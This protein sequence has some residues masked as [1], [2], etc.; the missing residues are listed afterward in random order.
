MLA[1]LTGL[2]LAASV[3]GTVRE[4]GTRDPVPGAVVTVAGQDGGVATD[5][6]GRFRLELAEGTWSLLIEGPAH[7]SE[8]ADVVV[9]MDAPLVVFLRPD[10]APPEIVVEA[11]VASPHHARSVLDRERVEKTPGTHDDP[12]RLIQAL[13]GVVMTPEYSPSG[14]AIALRGAR[15]GESRVYLDGVEIPYL[16]H[17]QQYAS[18]VHTRLLD[19]VAVYPSAFAANYGD[20]TGGVVA[21][22]S[23]EPDPAQVHGGVTLNT[24]MGGGY[25][26]APIGDRVAVSA[27]ARRSYADL[28]EDSNDQ[29]TS[30]PVFWDYLSRVDL[31]PDGESRYALTVLGA[32]D[33]YG[34]FASDTAALDPVEAA[35][36]PDFRYGRRFHGALASAR[37]TGER[38]ESNSVVGFTDEA[39]TGGLG[40]ALQ[41]R[42]ERALTLRHV[43]T[44]VRGDQLQLR[45]GG[46]A[47]AARTVLLADTTRPWPELGV[48]APLL[49]R[50]IGVDRVVSRLGGGAFVEPKV[51]LGVVELQPGIRVQADSGIGAVGLEP[52]GSLR[53][54]PR[55]D[56]TLRAAAGRYL[57]APEPEAL[58]PRLGDPGL[59]WSRALQG[60]AGVDWAIA[61]RWEV[62]VDG[63]ARVLE[64]GVRLPVDGELEVLD[65]Q[66]AGVELTTRYRIRERFF[67]W[68]SLTMGQSRLGGAPT[69]FDQPYAI[70]TVSSWDFRPGWNAGLRWRYAAG[71]P[72]TPVTDS[73]YD[74]DTDAY[75][76]VAGEPYSTRLPDYQ[77]LDLH[78]ERDVVFRRWTLAVYA[79][80]WWVPV[81]NN[82]L[83]RVYSYDYLE[84]ADVKGPPV[85]PLLGARAEL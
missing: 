83:Y 76:P 82:V 21:V 74:G 7:L 31:R 47:R 16:Y 13:P 55:H 28:G 8:T 53:L 41:D 9:P 18:V 27:S 46:D 1:F 24:I 52:R 22:R 34:R 17:F 4:R 66:A 84:S 38:F 32:G 29:Y 10:R 30:W 56:F 60:A 43:T 44:L 36:A 12:L 2:A 42:G 85:L 77:K 81:E 57:Q 25:V 69:A 78:L 80:V 72:L 11:E 40:V 75:L 51:S 71:L 19:E 64:D 14:G 59:S 20:A 3:D 37:H 49:A 61:G 35:E 45:F 5:A 62:A 67:S 26:Q 73:V 63:W 33:R 79:E 50:G 70:S 65:G 58:D 6:A 48:E 39:W 68:V 23:R 54:R 15:P